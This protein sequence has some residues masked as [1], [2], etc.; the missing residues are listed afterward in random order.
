MF[1]QWLFVIYFTIIINTNYKNKKTICLICYI[2]HK[3]QFEWQQIIVFHNI[4]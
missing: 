4:A 3:V 2:F 1:D